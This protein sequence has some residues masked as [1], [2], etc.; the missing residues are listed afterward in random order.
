MGFYDLVDAFEKQVPIEVGG[1]RRVFRF[2]LKPV[3][4]ANI[5]DAELV[6]LAHYRMIPGDV[7]REVYER[8]GGRC[9]QCGST[10]NLHFDHT[11][12]Y[13]KGGSSKT[14]SNIQLLCARHNLTK[15]NKFQ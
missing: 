8:D 6:D 10:D 2:W 14:A 7:Q 3:I 11:L 9:T 13:S 1:A 5:T 4:E 15:G 12:P